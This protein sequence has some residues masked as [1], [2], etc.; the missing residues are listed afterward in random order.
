MKTHRIQEKIFQ[1]KKVLKMILE[2][3]FLKSH[4]VCF[5]LLDFKR[6]TMHF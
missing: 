5:T 3:E 6:V 4:T 1:P 2:K